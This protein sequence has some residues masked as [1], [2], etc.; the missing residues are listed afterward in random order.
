MGIIF[1]G[2]FLFFGDQLSPDGFFGNIL[3]VLSG[4]TS[5]IMIV[6]FRA[7]KDAHPE[8]SILIA[9]LVMAVIGIPSI[10]KESHTV[11]NWL[12]VAY[13]GIFQIGLA[14]ILFTKGIRHIPALE[15]NLGLSLPRRTD[16]T[17]RP[18]GRAGGA[19]G[20]HRQCGGICAVRE[21]IRFM[22]LRTEGGRSLPCGAKQSPPK[23]V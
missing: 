11:T 7:Q 5:A 2:M 20:G 14:F 22:S 16:G 15:A 6:S 8:D 9:S 4:V 3:A 12:T 10:L 13:L 17:L 18:A 19:N 21:G 1:L 23:G